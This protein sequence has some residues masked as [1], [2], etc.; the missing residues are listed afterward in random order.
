MF[1][2]END[3]YAIG[4]ANMNLWNFKHPIKTKATICYV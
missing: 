1:Q 2:S 3:K 4:M